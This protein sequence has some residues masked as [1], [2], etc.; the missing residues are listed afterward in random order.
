MPYALDGLELEAGEP[1]FAPVSVLNQLRRDAVSALTELQERHDPG[2]VTRVQ[3][4]TAKTNP[5]VET[6]KP[7]LH[8]LVR[9]PEQL[10]AAL[11]LSPASITLDY[12]DLYGLRPSVERGKAAGIPVRVAS[13][14]IL[15][16]GESKIVNF[17]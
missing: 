10:D 16:P 11:E 1:V 14:R 5:T 6:G 8:L 12:L 3:V 9:T 15:K 4:P 7:V 17:L 2:P 13:P